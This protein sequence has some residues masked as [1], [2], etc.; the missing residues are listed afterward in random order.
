MLLKWSVKENE[1]G[2]RVARTRNIQKIVENPEWKD[3]LGD[4]DVNGR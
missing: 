1:M 2:E 3:H 4:Q